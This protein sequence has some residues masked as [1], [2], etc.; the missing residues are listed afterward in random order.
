MRKALALLGVLG[1]LA[2][3]GD[4]TGPSN[5]YPAV[6]GT[7]QVTGTF[8]AVPETF[9]GTMTLI[10]ADRTVGSLSG[11]FN[12]TLSGATPATLSGPLPS[13]T[14][15]SKAGVL[16]FTFTDASGGGSSWT[17]NGTLNN[18]TFTGRHVLTGS[19]SSFA[20]AW[21]ATRP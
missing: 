14:T 3:G 19:G 12:V 6:A 15:L 21:T 16:D 7:Y 13:T 8:D 18:K 2:C 10:Q 11:T 9:S 4:S 20:G 17:F 1:A 5:Q